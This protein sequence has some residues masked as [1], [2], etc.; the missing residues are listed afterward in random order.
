LGTEHCAT[1]QTLEMRN[2]MV[3][4]GGL[5]SLNDTQA[6]RGQAA[7]P[8]LQLLLLESFFVVLWSLQ[9]NLSRYL[10]FAGVISS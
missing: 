2:L 8:Y 7:L 1:N 6:E 5:L 4:E 10:F 9:S 3:G